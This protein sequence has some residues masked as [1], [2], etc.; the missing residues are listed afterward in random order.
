MFA[1]RLEVLEMEKARRKTN[2]TE[3]GLAAS[4]RM[5]ELNMSKE[6]LAARIGTSSTYLGFIFNGTRSGAKYIENIVNIL[7]L[8]SKFIQ[9]G[10]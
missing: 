6:Y 8:D 10:E 4:M 7:E 3:F 1:E 5:L 2:L 9:K